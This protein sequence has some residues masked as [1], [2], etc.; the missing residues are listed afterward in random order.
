MKN[1]IVIVLIT[2]FAGMS[3]S[4][5]KYLDAKPNGKLVIPNT[6]PDLQALLDN[7]AKM[8]SKDA[9]SAEV[10]AGDYFLTD[11][12][13]AAQT[14]TY[15][16]M[17]TWQKDF[18]FDQGYNDWSNIYRVVYT[19]NTILDNVENIDRNVNPVQW[20]M[21]KGQGYFHRGRALMQASF[22]WALAYDESSAVSDMGLPLRLNPDFHERSTRA[23]VQQTYEQV[24]N[25]L[26]L[27][28]ALLPVHT[29]HP[30]RPSKPAAFALMARTYLSMRRYDLAGQYAD[31]CL[32]L[33]DTLLDYN[34]SNSVHPDDFFPF[35]QLKYSNPEMLFESN[36][37]SPFPINP[38]IATID[39]A[40]YNS[41]DAND[42]R[43]TIFF[44]SKGNGT[45]EFHGSYEGTYSLFSGIATDEIYLIKAEVYAR[46]GDYDAA[47]NVL[48]RLLAKRW[49]KGKFL[50]LTASNAQEAINIILKERRKELLMRGLRWVDIKRLNKE[51]SNITLVRQANG[52][53]YTLPPNDLRYALPIPEDV[54]NLSGMPQNTR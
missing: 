4:C 33:K 53:N 38:S 10:S 3:P 43:K 50:P 23:S 41:Y 25:D 32:L 8:N 11:A 2:L 20:D 52:Q 14:E 44:K 51:G 42:L 34:D 9:G 54:I 24:I 17:Y 29:I 39:T 16:R 22:I 28:A 49:K 36:M 31:S 12:N 6:L 26:R 5:R 1:H 45:F 48:N 35:G 13:Y 27:A 46:G 40:L 47:I 15:K 30:L 37:S 21:V 18:L 7:D 19:A